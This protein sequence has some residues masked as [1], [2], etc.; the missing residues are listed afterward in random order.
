V[1]SGAG[2]TFVELTPLAEAMRAA[3]LTRAV[4]HADETPVSMVK[5][6]LGHTHKAYIWSDGSTQFDASP[7]VVYDFTE[8]RAGHHARTFV[9][10]CIGAPCHSVMTL[11]VLTTPAV[12]AAIPSV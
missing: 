3:L 4:L 10:S 1:I 8:S 11:A 7:L 2:T 12:A 5:P 9:G 6:G